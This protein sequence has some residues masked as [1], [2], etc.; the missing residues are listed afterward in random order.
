MSTKKQFIEGRKKT[1]LRALDA[2]VFLKAFDEYVHDL[3][4][5]E[6]KLVFR[7]LVLRAG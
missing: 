7:L 6:S 3:G 2:H 1:R 5:A 4:R